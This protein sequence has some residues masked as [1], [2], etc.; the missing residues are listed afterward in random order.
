MADA[1]DWGS[2]S[3]VHQLTLNDN[4]LSEGNL[5]KEEKRKLD[6][7]NKRDRA[8]RYD[9]TDRF[10]AGNLY[11]NGFNLQKGTLIDFR[12]RDH[13]NDSRSA[14]GTITSLYDTDPVKFNVI[15]EWSDAKPETFVVSIKSISRVYIKETWEWFS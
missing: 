2:L 7:S 3:Y 8:I 15:V 1:N 9:T 10:N 12:Y 6:E 14:K 13:R 4:Y 5:T 11:C